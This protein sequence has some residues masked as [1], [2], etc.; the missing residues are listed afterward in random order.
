MSRLKNTS[1]SQAVRLL[2]PVHPV[3]TSFLHR[4]PHWTPTY[5]TKL[6]APITHPLT[7]EQEP[8]RAQCVTQ[9]CRATSS[10]LFFTLY[11]INNLYVYC[12]ISYTSLTRPFSICCTLFKTLLFS[13]SCVH[14]LYIPNQSVLQLELEWMKSTGIVLIVLYLTQKWCYS[15]IQWHFNISYFWFTGLTY[16]Q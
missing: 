12:P 7:A 15:S 4:N 8:I 14:M 1:Y 9:Y 6:W 10:L 5:N 3:F 13:S 16:L 11:E 2:T